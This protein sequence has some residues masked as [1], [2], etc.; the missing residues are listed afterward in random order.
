MFF[1]TVTSSLQLK[2]ARRDPSCVQ[3]Q[4]VSCVGSNAAGLP[5][6]TGSLSTHA[7]GSINRFGFRRRVA[8]AFASVLCSPR[9]PV[10]A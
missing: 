6:L 1:T 4:H 2:T 9:F 5:Q 8:L 7:G 10:P 3:Y